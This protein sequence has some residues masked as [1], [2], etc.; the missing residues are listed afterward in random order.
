MDI[1]SIIQQVRESLLVVLDTKRSED[2]KEDHARLCVYRA[3]SIHPALGMMKPPTHD[4]GDLDWYTELGPQLGSLSGLFKKLGQNEHFKRTS[5]LGESGRRARIMMLLCWVIGHRLPLDRVRQL[6]STAVGD[7]LDSTETKDLADALQMLHHD[8]VQKVLKQIAS[9]I[10]TRLPLPKERNPFYGEDFIQEDEDKAVPRAELWVYNDP[11]N[12]GYTQLRFIMAIKLIR[13]FR[14]L[15]HERY[16]FDVKHN[17]TVLLRPMASRVL[18]P[19]TKLS[20]LVVQ[21]TTRNFGLGIKVFKREDIDPDAF[22]NADPPRRSFPPMP[23]T[24]VTLELDDTDMELNEGYKT[25]DLDGDDTS[26]LSDYGLSL[27]DAFQDW[28]LEEWI[29]ARFCHVYHLHGWAHDRFVRV[30]LFSLFSHQQ[31][32]PSNDEVLTAIHVAKRFRRRLGD[33]ICA[34]IEPFVVANSMKG[35]TESGVTGDHPWI[36]KFRDMSKDERGLTVIFSDAARE[37]LNLD[38]IMEPGPPTFYEAYSFL[39]DPTVDCP[40]QSDI[41]AIPLVEDSSRR[42]HFDVPSVD[43]ERCTCSNCV[44]SQYHLHQDLDHFQMKYLAILSGSNMSGCHAI[45]MAW[46]PFMTEAERWVDT[47]TNRIDCPFELYPNISE[48]RLGIAIV[49]VLFTLKLNIGVHLDTRQL[50]RFLTHLR[51]RHL[52]P[53]Q[54]SNDTTELLK[55]NFAYVMPADPDDENPL[56]V[57]STAGGWLY[58]LAGGGLDDPNATIY[59]IP[60]SETLEIRHISTSIPEIQAI[61]MPEREINVPTII[62]PDHTAMDALTTT[63]DNMSDLPEPSGIIMELSEDVKHGFS[64]LGSSREGYGVQ[65]STTYCNRLI[66]TWWRP[67]VEVG[68]PCLHIPE[69]GRMTRCS[70]TSDQVLLQLKPQSESNIQLE[71]S[72]EALL[73]NPETIGQGVKSAFLTEHKEKTR[74]LTAWQAPLEPGRLCIVRC[75]PK[76]GPVDPVIL[77]AGSLGMR[78]YIFHFKECWNCACLRMRALG[79]TLGI[80]FGTKVITKCGHC[81]LADERARRIITE[82]EIS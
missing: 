67:K 78:V 81:T 28:P 71:T 20:L 75:G 1:G 50:L 33:D 39:T 43:P 46:D 2:E 45:E 26:M 32:L 56:D 9:M 38:S 55:D 58:D 18:V 54:F 42:P 70:L 6:L 68:R 72:T 34:T 79:C 47:F 3:L 80:A 36:P 77:L 73:V 66:Q 69:Y 14:L 51:F 22:W 17:P 21:W 16:E 7:A 30:L 44:T 5:L 13:G 40:D 19:Q 31:S 48:R 24:R 4:L 64:F 65:L 23:I 11:L 37:V 60:N 49:E 35:W 41:L 12:G 76:E 82:L 59:F 52:Y 53:E 57:L 15:D 8:L 25:D 63:F 29:H 61:H 27:A 10:K 62:P 74:H